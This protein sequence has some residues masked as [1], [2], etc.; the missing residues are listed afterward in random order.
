MAVART[1]KSLT[2]QKFTEGS[3]ALGFLLLAPRGTKTGLS[4]SRDR[5]EARVSSGSERTAPGRIANGYLLSNS[6]IDRS[7]G[8]A[9]NALLHSQFSPSCKPDR[10]VQVYIELQLYL[11]V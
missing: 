10:L 9:P 6:P 3:E 1:T 11:E 7:P 5:G 8:D 2:E 4:P